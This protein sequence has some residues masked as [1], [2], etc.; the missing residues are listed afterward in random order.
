MKGVVLV[1]GPERFLA[2]EAVV[3]I[4]VA[5]PD[6]EVTRYDGTET[7]P[8]QVLDDLRTPTLFG[9]SRAVVVDNAGEMLRA[10]LEA[11]AA[12]ARHPAPGALLVLVAT[13]LDGRLKGAKQLR[14]A[15]ELVDCQPLGQWEIGKW[16]RKRGGDAYGLQMGEAAAGALRRCVGEDMGLLDAALARLKEQI[17]PRIFLRPEDVEGSTEEHRSPALFE[18]GNALEDRDLPGALGAVAA[19]F[20]E[21]IRINEGV[22]GEEAA[23]A[24][25]LLD[26]LHKAYVKLIR[27]HLQRRLG[28]P[29]EEAARRAG[30]S[31]G[32]MRFFLPRANKHRLD[33]LVARHRHFAEADSA[34]KG[35]GPA[36]GRKVL[37]RLL[38]ALLTDSGVTPTSDYR[39]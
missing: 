12:Y 6:L 19:A 26:N 18:P 11:F 22:V 33:T 34:L 4:L 3:R 20:D 7:L 32:A 35:E 27:F 23:V 10:A 36:D 13:G 25:I 29:E 37:E 21:G 17:S 9:G 15:A 30:C 28:V 38:L 24:P 16:I 5:R 39:V 1:L 14:E 8:A 2:R 31:P